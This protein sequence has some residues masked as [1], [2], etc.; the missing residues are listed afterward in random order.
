MRSLCSLLAARILKK[1]ARTSCPILAVG[2]ADF[3]QFLLI[4]GIGTSVLTP[5]F[6][7][8]ELQGAFG[9]A[10]AQRDEAAYIYRDVVI[11]AYKEAKDAYSS[12]SFI[13]AERASTKRQ[14]KAAREALAH[15]K[16]RYNTG[17]SS[18]LEVIDAQRSLL[19]IETSLIA[20]KTLYMESLCNLYGALGGGIEYPRELLEER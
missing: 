13:N 4:G 17:Y 3:T 11:Q 18:Y 15:A 10:N 19:E 9:I 5:L 7:G 16:E 20:L 12:L 14:Q 1:R 8:G 2:Y 6:K